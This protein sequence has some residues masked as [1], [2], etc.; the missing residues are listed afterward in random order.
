MAA[1]DGWISVQPQPAPSRAEAIRR[2]LT[3][4]LSATSNEQAPKSKEA[5]VKATRLAEQT[6]N[7]AISKDAAPGPE[8]ERRK[9][10]LLKGHKNSR[11]TE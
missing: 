10:R 4:A 7:K 8:L 9:R 11:R 6:L 3:Q 1:L 5:N 2:L